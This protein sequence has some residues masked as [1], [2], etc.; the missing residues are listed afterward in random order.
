VCVWSPCNFHLD[1]CIRMYIRKKTQFCCRRRIFLIARNKNETCT[2]TRF[3]RVGWYTRVT[4]YQAVFVSILLKSTVIWMWPMSQGQHIILSEF[5][6]FKNKKFAGFF[7]CNS[8]IYNQ[9]QV[10]KASARSFIINLCHL[11]RLFTR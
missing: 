9:R 2:H 4:T 7:S 11:K 1:K 10:E 5:S 8:F 6:T 3:L